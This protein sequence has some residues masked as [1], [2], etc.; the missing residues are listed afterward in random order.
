MSI[1]AFHEFFRKET[2]MN[3]RVTYYGKIQSKYRQLRKKGINETDAYE[4]LASDEKN[5]PLG[6]KAGY[7]RDIVNR[8]RF[9]NGKIPLT[10]SG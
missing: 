10:S 9:K 5:N 8:K 2:R 7:I 6:W 1:E 4:A 3:I